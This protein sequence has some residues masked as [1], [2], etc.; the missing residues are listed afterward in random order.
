MGSKKATGGTKS[1]RFRTLTRHMR[2]SAFTSLPM[3]KQAGVVAILIIGISVMAMLI[4][5]REPAPGAARNDSRTAATPAKNAGMVP[6]IGESTGTT[7]SPVDMASNQ[8]VTMVKPV[9]ITGCL[10]RNDD[11]FKLKDTSGADA[12]KSR[13]W[14]TGFLKKGSAPIQIVDASH[15]LKLTD[16]VGK[17][18]SVTGVLVDREMR[19]RSVQRVAASCTADSKVKT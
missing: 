13:S 2:L 15:R 6:A 9:T 3:K 4:D 19:A 18:V 11:T 12:P 1:A 7:G 14:K 8:P 10:E 5:S 17:R 16:H